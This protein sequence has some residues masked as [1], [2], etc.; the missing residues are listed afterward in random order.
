[1]LILSLVILD[2]TFESVG[3]ARQAVKEAIN[4][5]NTLRLHLSL[6]YLAPEAKHVA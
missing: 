6:G 5:Y 3:R 4:T 2:S 1:M